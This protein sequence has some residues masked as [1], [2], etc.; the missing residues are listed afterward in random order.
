MHMQSLSRAF[1]NRARDF[2]RPDLDPYI[3]PIPI[4][5][6][7]KR[8]KMVYIFLVLHFGENFTK[9]WTKIAKLQMHE[10]LHTFFM[11]IFMTYEA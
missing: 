8:P 11:Q 10:N 4:Q 5:K 7:G 3:S 2:P 9:I 1:S 6:W